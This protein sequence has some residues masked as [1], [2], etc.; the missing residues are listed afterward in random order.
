MKLHY[1]ILSAILLLSILSSCNDDQRDLHDYYFPLRELT[2]GLVYEFRDLNFDSLSADY[3]YY[4]TIPT[5]S[6]FYF[7]KAYYQSD[8]EQKQLYREVMVNNGILL[9]DLFLFENDSNGQQLQTQA[10]ILSPNV[11]PFKVTGSEDYYI[12]QVRFQLSSQPHGSTSVLINRRF[13]GDTTYQFK[14]Q[15]YD[16]IQ[17]DILGSVDQ[18]DSIRGDIEPQFSGREIYAEGLGLVYYERSYGPEAPSFQHQLVDRYPMQEL[19]EQ[20]RHSWEE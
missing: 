20:A 1:Q 8:F 12:Y 10:E 7:T 19:T 9:K 2:D 3:W 14:G 13:L 6:A 17:F 16:A 11:F 15:T 4:R 18:R 5:D